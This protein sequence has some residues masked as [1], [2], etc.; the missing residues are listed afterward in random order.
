MLV[1][2]TLAVSLAFA[3]LFQVLLL[4]LPRAFDLPLSLKLSLDWQTVVFCILAAFGTAVLCGVAPALQAAQPDLAPALK[5]SSTNLSS[6]ERSWL[7]SAL[8]IVQVAFSMILLVGGCIF[9]RTVLAAYSIDPGFHSDHLL[10]ASL[11]SKTN[12]GGEKTMTSVLENATSQ[13]EQLAGVESVTTAWDFPLSGIYRPLRFC[14]P[15]GRVQPHFGWLT[16][17]LDLATCTQ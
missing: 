11:D 5:N 16:T 3:A 10:V 14:R 2:L 17:W 4:H 1:A 13:T 7:R 8:V 9:A 6:D 12:S 15:R